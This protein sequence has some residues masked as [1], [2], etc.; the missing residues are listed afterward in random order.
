MPEAVRPSA[1]VMAECSDKG[2]FHFAF[3]VYQSFLVMLSLR[4]LF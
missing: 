4:I 2:R 1:P 3:G